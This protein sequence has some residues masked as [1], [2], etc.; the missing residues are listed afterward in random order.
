MHKNTFLRLISEKSLT[1]WVDVEV[2][3]Y[4]ALNLCYDRKW[5]GGIER[6]NSDFSIIKKA[7]ENYLIQQT[8][9]EKDVLPEIRDKITAI[10]SKSSATL[11]LNFNY[12]N[13]ETLYCP[14][15]KKCNII[16]IH[17]ELENPHN[18]IIFGYG[19]DTD[20]S[21]KRIANN[22]DDNYLENIKSFRYK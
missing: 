20:D 2:E 9:S 3:Y 7:L 1:N 22:Y 18:P 5:E 12:T 10:V 8:K 14:D 15:N 6:L 4:H 13:T 16:H 19:D 21:Y 17:G 11:F